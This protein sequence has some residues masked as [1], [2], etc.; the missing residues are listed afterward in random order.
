LLSLPDDWE[1]KVKTLQIKGKAGRDKVYGIIEE[2]AGA[3]Y[4]KRPARTRDDK[5][6]VSWTPY[7]VYESPLEDNTING[8]SGT[9]K[10]NTDEPDTDEPDTGEPHI[11]KRKS[12]RKNKTKEIDTEKDTQ[13]G[14]TRKM[15]FASLNREKSF[16]N[17]GKPVDPLTFQP[18]Y[19]AIFY[20][21]LDAMNEAGFALPL[22]FQE[23][24][25][26]QRDGAVAMA[27]ARIRVEDLKAYV[28]TDVLARDNN[29]RNWHLDN[30]KR[31]LL[32]T[33][34]NRIGTW[35]QERGAEASASEQKG[36][37][38]SEHSVNGS[39]FLDTPEGQRRDLLGMYFVSIEE[40]NK[41][42]AE[43]GLAPDCSIE[44]LKAALGQQ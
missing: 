36:S 20:A 25:N 27:R 24:W 9:G 32:T 31:P 35:L 34:A 16:Y 7:E 8:F 19:N 12:N 13:S 23:E 21:A 17:D 38:W 1:V 3:G 18:E 44:D 40:V 41:R 2:L 30:A 42:L 37:S 28:L 29:G 10:P 22:D 11:N 15:F 4:I 39:N 43:L 5:G 33:I 26:R 14:A 6:R